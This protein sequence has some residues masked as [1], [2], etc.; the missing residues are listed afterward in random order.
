[1]PEVLG[2]GGSIE[3]RPGFPRRPHGV[4]REDEGRPA[5]EDQHGH[6]FPEGKS[7]TCLAENPPVEACRCRKYEGYD[8]E[9]YAGE[10]DDTLNSEHW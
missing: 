5:G 6:E 10:R 8:E 7:A 2:D 4:G 3:E 9:P 1:V